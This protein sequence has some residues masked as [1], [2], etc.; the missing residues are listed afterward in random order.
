LYLLYILSK[1]ELIESY[2][3]VYPF[4]V[5]ELKQSE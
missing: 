1:T 2:I 5:V 4:L 3:V